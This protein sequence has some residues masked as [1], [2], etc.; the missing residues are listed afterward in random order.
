MLEGRWSL[1]YNSKDIMEKIIVIVFIGVFVIEV[2]VIIIGNIFIIF[3]FWIKRVYFK[4]VCFL[5]ISLVVVD[6]FVGIIEFFVFGVKKFEKM[7]LFG[8]KEGEIM[9]FLIVF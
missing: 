4:W 9:S 8:N 5:L 7:I 2:I 3:V 1:N 6:L